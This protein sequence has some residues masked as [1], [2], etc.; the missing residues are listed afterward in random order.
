M[1]FLWLIN[2]EDANDSDIY[3]ASKAAAFKNLQ[4][5]QL[6][7]LVPNLVTIYM[8]SHGAFQHSPILNI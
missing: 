1:H 4:M 3:A 6:L 8:P 2:H 5:S 7:V